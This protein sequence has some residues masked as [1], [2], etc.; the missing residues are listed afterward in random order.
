MT[1][2]T[3]PRYWVRG[4]WSRRVMGVMRQH[5]D[6]RAQTRAWGRWVDIPASVLPRYDDTMADVVDEATVLRI[7]ADPELFDDDDTPDPEGEARHAEVLALLAGEQ[8]KPRK[9]RAA[10]R[11]A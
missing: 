1:T 2:T 6:G 3:T 11:K 5:P 9:R 10:R 7:I 4:G 8:A